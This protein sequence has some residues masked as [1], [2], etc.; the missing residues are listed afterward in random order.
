MP[1]M[2]V[3]YADMDLASKHLKTGQLDI[4]QKLH[5]LK[6]M[7]DDL[8]REG[9]VTDSSSVAF[10]QSYSEFNDGIRKVVL[11]LDGMSQYLTQASTALRSTDEELARG[12]R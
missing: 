7:V 9:Y 11:G 12:L 4:E 2:K 1:N 6:N 5:E 3:T 10:E 8:V